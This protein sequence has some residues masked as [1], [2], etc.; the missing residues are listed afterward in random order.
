MIDAVK[1]KAIINKPER[2]P[3]RKSP[4]G[5]VCFILLAL[6]ST[7]LF[8]FLSLATDASTVLKPNP[9]ARLESSR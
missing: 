3:Q 2:R 8:L 9:N 1:N 5:I 7:Q 6:L 4:A